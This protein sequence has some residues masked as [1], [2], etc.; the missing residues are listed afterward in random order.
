VPVPKPPPPL[1]PPTNPPNPTEK[2]E[3]NPSLSGPPFLFSLVCAR[4]PATLKLHF[5]FCAQRHI[6][7]LG[8]SRVKPICGTHSL[9]LAPSSLNLVAYFRSPFSSI[10]TNLS[11][12]SRPPSPPL[13]PLFLPA[14]MLAPSLAALSTI[15]QPSP[16]QHAHLETAGRL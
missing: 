6:S 16:S 7:Y 12:L 13:P 5:I 2:E 15:P 10:I 1:F 3:K 4:T 14:L 8:H 9:V 11:F